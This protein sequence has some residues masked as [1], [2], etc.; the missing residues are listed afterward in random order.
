M[1]RVLAELGRR[2]AASGERL[3]E[4][5]IRLRVADWQTRRVTEQGVVTPLKAL[6]RPRK[7]EIAQRAGGVNYHMLM[8]REVNRGLAPMDAMLISLTR[9][10]G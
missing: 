8:K 3:P 6:Q 4:A 5:L 7:L 9:G 2:H 10:Y 1:H